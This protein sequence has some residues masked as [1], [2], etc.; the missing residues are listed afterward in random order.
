MGLG[1]ILVQISFISVIPYFIVVLLKF[2]L[3]KFSFTA[4]VSG[5]TNFSEIMLRGI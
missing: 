4:G 5:F 1:S 3:W 2:F